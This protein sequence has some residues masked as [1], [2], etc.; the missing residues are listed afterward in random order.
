MAELEFNSILVVCMG[1]ICR[2]P[3]G[4]RLLQTY[5]PHKIVHSAGLGAPNDA[6]ADNTAI[7]IATKHGISLEGHKSK[8]FTIQMSRQYD[9]ILVME[10]RHIE[11]ITKLAP[12]I[13]GKTLLFGHWFNQQ[14]IAD[15]Y[16]KSKELF[17]L[18]YQ[19]LENSAKRWVSVLQN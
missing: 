14:E 10:K 4:E 1:N 5:L 13:R 2:S 12:E 19:Q 7:E 18:V 17:E 16:R 3:I 9:L 15:P 8:P 11:M 6:P